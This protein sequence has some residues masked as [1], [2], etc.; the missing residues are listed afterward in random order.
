MPEWT[1]EEDDLARAL[2]AKAQVPIE[3]LK[4]T[5]DPLKGPAVQKAGRQ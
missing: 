2:Q 3:G 4:R 1:K 5:I